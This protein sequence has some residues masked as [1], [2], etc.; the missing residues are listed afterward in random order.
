MKAILKTIYYFFAIFVIILLI[1]VV[2][3]YE[4]QAAGDGGFCY[5]AGDCGED[6]YCAPGFNAIWSCDGANPPNAG[7]CSAICTLGPTPPPGGGGACNRDYAGV[8]CPGGYEKSPN[9]IRSDCIS[10][11]QLL[12]NQ[13]NP[14][15]PYPNTNY[16][17]GTAQSVGACC[18]ENDDGF[19]TAHFLNEHVCVPACPV[20]T[21][22][23]CGLTNFGNYQRYNSC[24]TPNL[25]NDS[26]DVYVPTAYSSSAA[27]TCYCNCPEDEKCGSSC[28][29]GRNWI[30]NVV[31]TC[32]NMSYSCS[33]VPTGCTATSPSTPTLLSPANGSTVPTTQTSLQWNNSGVTFG[34][35]CPTNTNQFEIYVGTSPSSLALVGTVGNGTGSIT[36]NGTSGQIYYWKIRAKNGSNTTDSPVWSFTM[37]VPNLTPWWQVKDGDVTTNGNITSLVPTAALFDIVGLGGYPGVPVYGGVFNLTS[38]TAKI[39]ATRWNAN[40]NTSQSRLFNYSYFNNLIPD[41]VNFN[42]ISNLGSGGSAYSDSYHWF[43]ATGNTTIAS[44]VNIGNRKVILFVENGNLNINGKINLNDGNG[45]F[46]AFV[47]GNITVGNSVLGSPS[48]EGVY[49]SDGSFSTGAGAS[50]LHIRG[51]V[52]SFG[53]INLQRNLSNNATAAELFEFAPDQMFLFPEK[54]MFRRNKWAEVAP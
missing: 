23:Q 29:D 14:N 45:F 16:W 3:T 27:G 36:F 42:N 12:C 38:N 46:G 47:N 2:G 40:T 22:Q 49:L 25:C 44:D 18:A 9:L 10:D 7:T 43:K 17:V 53:G 24:F 39:S 8:D 35:G 15:Y 21:T 52:A 31:T 28:S 50:Q 20:G 11:R 51:S 34:T 41:D 54:L 4:V 13:P 48:L 33:C 19:C 26:N 5:T 32:Q 6:D 37:Q 30:Y 1:F